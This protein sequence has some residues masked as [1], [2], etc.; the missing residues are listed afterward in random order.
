M[1]DDFHLDAGGMNRWAALISFFG[2]W[3]S[4]GCCCLG[5]RRREGNR[6]LF[7]PNHQFG[8]IFWTRKMATVTH[9]QMTIEEGFGRIMYVAERGN[10]NSFCWAR[11][12]NAR[13]GFVW[14]WS[15]SVPTDVDPERCFPWS[16]VRRSIQR[17][18]EPSKT[19]HLCVRHHTQEG[20]VWIS[21]SLSS[22]LSGESNA[23]R[24][25]SVREMLVAVG[26][27]P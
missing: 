8:L 20:S 25:P 11:C 3:S 7:Q 22:A 1:T 14:T 27:I 23:A 24:D 2:L 4:L 18:L 5:T 17:V 21:V 12:F 16:L 19:P 26:A 15:R 10:M 13:V 6:L 9:V